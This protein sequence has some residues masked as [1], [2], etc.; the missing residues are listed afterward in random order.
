MSLIG[1]MT[2]SKNGIPTNKNRNTENVK[3]FL[4]DPT[5]TI[6]RDSF[7]V[8]HS[9]NSIVNILNSKKYKEFLQFLK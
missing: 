2:V 1:F 4:K 6:N 3:G 5:Q 9:T 8:Q 7:S